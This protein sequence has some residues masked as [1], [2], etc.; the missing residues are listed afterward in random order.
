[1]KLLTNLTQTN[2]QTNHNTASKTVKLPMKLPTKPPMKLI[3]QTDH[4]NCIQNYSWTKCQTDHENDFKLIHETTCQT[5][6][7]PANATASI[8]MQTHPSTNCQTATIWLH[9][10]A[11]RY[12]SNCQWNCLQNHIWYYL[13]NAHEDCK[14]SHKPTVKLLTNLP[15]QLLL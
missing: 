3:F 8:T 11:W 9:N 12:L 7:K 13:S 1:M 6:Y 15:M 10:Q 2:C 14:T 4:L 5:A